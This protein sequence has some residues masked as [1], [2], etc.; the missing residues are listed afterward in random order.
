MSRLGQSSLRPEDIA[1][2]PVSVRVVPL[3]A[4]QEHSIVRSVAFFVFFSEDYDE[5]VKEYEAAMR[6]PTPAGESIDAEDTTVETEAQAQA[7]RSAPEGDLWRQ[8]VEA[9]EQQDGLGRAPTSWA[10]EVDD[11]QVDDVGAAPPEAGSGVVGN[12]A[13]VS[14][15]ERRLRES[16][17]VTGYQAIP[18]QWSD[19]SDEEEDEGVPCQTAAAATADDNS[20]SNIDA[21]TPVDPA[22]ESEPLEQGQTALSIEVTISVEV[23]V[24]VEE[25]TQA[26]PVVRLPPIEEVDEVEEAVQARPVVRFPPVI[27]HEPAAESGSLDANLE[28]I[29]SSSQRR[30]SDSSEETN[31][32]ADTPPTSPDLDPINEDGDSSNSTMVAY[33]ESPSRELILS[34]RGPSVRLPIGQTGQLLV[35]HTEGVVSA[36]PGP[37]DIRRQPIIH[38]YPD[39]NPRRVTSGGQ[40]GMV[41][42]PRMYFDHRPQRLAERTLAIEAAPLA[43][44]PEDEEDEEDEEDHVSR[45]EESIA[46]EETIDGT[47]ITSN[48][49]LRTPRTRRRRAAR[50]VHVHFDPTPVMHTWSVATTASAT[51]S[52]LTIHEWAA[53]SSATAYDMWP[54]F[55]GIH[56]V[57]SDCPSIISSDSDAD[58]DSLLPTPPLPIF[59]RTRKGLKYASWSSIANKLTN[60]RSSAPPQFT[61]MAHAG[62]NQSQFFEFPE[63]RSVSNGRSVASKLGKKTKNVFKKGLNKLKKLFGLEKKSSSLNF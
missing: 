36:I 18:A 43:T 9:A 56:Y 37:F 63:S 59:R 13:P 4:P 54:D 48:V 25:A 16:D 20:G 33:S 58:N 35:D 30:H 29:G 32:D 22:T 49:T 28:D 24:E 42:S 44:V 51:S 17:A 39:G 31:S 62:W 47:I 21:S 15:W 2:V 7:N 11:E 26:S 57:E 40:R 45:L 46:A 23:T 27:D 10:D 38:V 5:R 19:D 8:R 55:N 50:H 41:R 14:D 60:R 6:R 12:E 61:I 52:L 3:H 53:Y 1:D 34:P